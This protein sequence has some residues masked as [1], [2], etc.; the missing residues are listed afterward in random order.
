MQGGLHANH[1]FRLDLSGQQV[2]MRVGWKNGKKICFGNG[3]V[4]INVTLDHEVNPE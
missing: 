4:L 2:R 1:D 3:I